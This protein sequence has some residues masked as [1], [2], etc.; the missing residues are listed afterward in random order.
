MKSGFWQWR[1]FAHTVKPGTYVPGIVCMVVVPSRSRGVQVAGYAV[2]TSRPNRIMLNEPPQP[3]H[4]LRQPRHPRLAKSGAVRM[5]YLGHSA[6]S[7]D[8]I[9]A[10]FS[11]G[12]GLR[13][14]VWHHEG[15]W[16][17]LAATSLETQNNSTVMWRG[18]YPVTTFVSWSFEKL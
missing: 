16:G 3:T 12:L 14:V 1:L 5:L 2:R 9:A 4:A 6:Y 7:T 18:T 10:Q 13:R 8:G 11:S 15:H 17:L